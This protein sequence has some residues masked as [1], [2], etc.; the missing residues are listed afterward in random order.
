MIETVKSQK[1]KITDVIKKKDEEKAE[2][3]SVLLVERAG[4]YQKVGNL[5]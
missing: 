3:L 4:I 1:N 2:D 5:V